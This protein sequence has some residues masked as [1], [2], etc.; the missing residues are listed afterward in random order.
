[1]A[2]EPKPYRPK[3]C[4]KRPLSSLYSGYEFDYDYYRDDFYSR[5]FEYHGRVVPP[6]RA[7]IPIKRSRLV[8]PS[9]RRA[10]SSFPVRAC[11]S[12]SSSSSS[13]SRALTVGSSIGGPK[14][15]TDHLLT[16]K[17]ELSH[18]KT[19]IDSL[20]GRLEKIERQHR[21]D[22]DIQRKQEEV[23]E[24]IHGDVADHCGGEEAEE[25]AEVEAGEM[26]DGGEDDFEDEGAGDMMENHISDIDN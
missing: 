22:V 2:G 7:V 4:S 11:S 14:L 12:S 15:K 24:C 9:T 23:Y 18:I 19:K 16:I 3:I 21:S 17:K 10:K 1:M 20:L 8:V 5:L 25:A 13:S 6:T 26:T